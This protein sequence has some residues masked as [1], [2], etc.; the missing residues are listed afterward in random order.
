MAN[1]NILID[2]CL[3]TNGRGQYDFEVQDKNIFIRLYSDELVFNKHEIDEKDRKE[4]KKLIKFVNSKERIEWLNSKS[5]NM[6]ILYM[7]IMIKAKTDTDFLNWWLSYNFDIDL[8]LYKD[9]K[10]CKQ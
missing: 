1:N 5:F 8:F 10:W 3:V 4:L 2:A 7:Y 6:S 9:C